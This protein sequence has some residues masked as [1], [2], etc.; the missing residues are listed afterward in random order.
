[1]AVRKSRPGNRRT[2][3]GPIPKCSLTLMLQCTVPLPLV[4]LH[5]RISQR[6]K[7]QRPKT[8]LVFNFAGFLLYIVQ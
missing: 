7:T 5:L 2:D 3:F 1:M 4:F 8:F 6:R